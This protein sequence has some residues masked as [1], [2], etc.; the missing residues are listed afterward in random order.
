[1]TR[2]VTTQKSPKKVYIVLL[3]WRLVFFSI[4][5]PNE[6]TF[7]SGLHLQKARQPQESYQNQT[8]LWGGILNVALPLCLASALPAPTPGLRLSGSLVEEMILSHSV[9]VWVRMQCVRLNPAPP[10]TILRVANSCCFWSDFLIHP[11]RLPPASPWSS[12]CSLGLQNITIYCSLCATDEKTCFS[13]QQSSL[14]MIEFEFSCSSGVCDA[15]IRAD[16]T[17]F[18]SFF[19]AK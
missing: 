16:K 19:A 4:R 14:R 6:W 17:A 3:F 18:C 2:P 13:P 7:S 10:Q 9:R 1:M 5:K 8:C 15:E 12:V 11:R